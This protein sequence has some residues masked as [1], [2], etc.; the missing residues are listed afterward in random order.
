MQIHF[1]LFTQSLYDVTTSR[2]VP[3]SNGISI[4]PE[5]GGATDTERSDAE[6]GSDAYSQGDRAEETQSAGLW[7]LRHG[8]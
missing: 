2:L 7:S 6:P 1:F 4:F 8:L 5:A 3:Y